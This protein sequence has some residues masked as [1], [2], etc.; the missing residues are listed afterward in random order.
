MSKR[1]P[2]LYLLPYVFIAAAFAGLLHQGVFAFTGA[3]VVLVFHPIL[4][5]MIKSP[6]N[7]EPTEEANSKIY[8]LSL[9]LM[10]PL[11]FAFLI[12]S[13]RMLQSATSEAEVVGI[14][15]TSGIM[16]GAFGITTAHELVHRRDKF[17]EAMGYAILV[18]IHFTHFAVC[19]IKGHHK[20][21]AT[22]ADPAT[23]KRGES[24]Y[25]YWLRSIPG[26]FFEAYEIEKERAQKSTESRG[27]IVGAISI[28]LKNRVVRFTFLSVFLLLVV[29]SSWG[30]NIA[31]AWVIQSV[32]ALLILS[33]VDYIE[34]YGLQRR[35]LKP[36]V[37]EPV[38]PWHSWDSTKSMTNW[39]LFNLALHSDHHMKVQKTY[40]QLKAN[41]DAAMLPFGYSTMFLL[42]FLPP[43]YKRIMDPLIP[44]QREV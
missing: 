44:S 20:H 36:G 43:V 5:A 34:H 29:T 42:A 1:A 30:A 25:A 13:W 17:E 19:H 31:V 21:V 4:D 40:S 24:L 11:L 15:L 7:D 14:L 12:F 32:I 10:F 27:S 38:R 39:S 35:E 3:I 9:Y 41:P 18:L 33:T 2:F 6:L 23:A 8:N 16:M 26:E 22:P 28:F 37:F